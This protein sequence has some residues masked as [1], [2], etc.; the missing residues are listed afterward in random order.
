LEVLV[1]KSGADTFPMPPL[2][3]SMSRVSGV[4]R[5]GRSEI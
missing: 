4:L 1:N 5:A 3:T 2:I